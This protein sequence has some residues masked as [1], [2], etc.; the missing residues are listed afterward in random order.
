[1]I[2]RGRYT[3]VKAH[4]C[5]YYL[6]LNSLGV[7][8]EHCWLKRN[9]LKSPCDLEYIWFKHSNIISLLC[10]QLSFLSV[11]PSPAAAPA[12]PPGPCWH[13]LTVCPPPRGCGSLHHPHPA[14][15]AVT[16]IL[17]ELCFLLGRGPKLKKRTEA[18]NHSWCS[19][20]KRHVG[21]N[22]CFGALYAVG[23]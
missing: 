18:D 23:Y 16:A 12:L 5:K 11:S 6:A 2:K 21:A 3:D 13:L 22:S 4:Y 20:F 14:T 17:S 15:M 7:S 19:P 10:A 8:S 1:M 9:N